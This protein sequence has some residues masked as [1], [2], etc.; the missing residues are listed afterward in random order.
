MSF[1]SQARHLVCVAIFLVTPHWVNAEVARSTQQ[2]PA[3]VTVRYDEAFDLFN[4]LDNLPD[5]L[6]G[7]T[8]AIYQQ[9]WERRFGLDA[10][11]QAALEAY[12]GFRKR[13]SPIAHDGAARQ[14]LLLACKATAGYATLSYS[15]RWCPLS[16]ATQPSIANPT[17]FGMGRSPLR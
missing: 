10:K 2:A 16:R 1:R 15:S 17:V 5:W 3:L 13:T 4:L 8:S 7:Y 11:D 14:I 12:A 9:D 6:P